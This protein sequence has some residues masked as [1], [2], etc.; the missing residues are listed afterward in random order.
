MSKGKVGQNK[1][2]KSYVDVAKFVA[3]W[4]KSSTVL[5]VSEK[6]NLTYANCK[7]RAKNL[8]KYGVQIPE[9][10]SGVGSR[11]RRKTDAESLNK[12]IKELRK[13][14]AV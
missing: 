6:L 14:K 3:T 4:M 11:G 13:A 2:K 12:M 9:L 7:I 8:E 1:P 10:P 5:E